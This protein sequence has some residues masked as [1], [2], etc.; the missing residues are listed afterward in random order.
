MNFKLILFVMAPGIT[1]SNAQ[2]SPTFKK[3]SAC[4]C[5]LKAKRIQS[6]DA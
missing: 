2:S 4:T 1:H 6:I 3:Q 5:Q